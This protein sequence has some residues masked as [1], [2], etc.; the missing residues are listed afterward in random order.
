MNVHFLLA[1]ALCFYVF[2]IF[3]IAVLMFKKRKAAVENKEVHHSFFKTYSGAEVPDD[4]IVIARHFDNQ[5]QVPMLFMV[6]GSLLLTF[7][8]LP[9]WVAVLAWVF[10]LSRAVHS[11]IHLGGNAILNRAKV[12]VLGWLILFVLW[13]KIVITFA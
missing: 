11:R 4:L 12:Y 13:I 10:V 6:T 1:M 7:V 2:Y 8:H 3:G 5:F 9:A